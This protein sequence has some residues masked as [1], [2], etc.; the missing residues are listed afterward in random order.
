MIASDKIR[1]ARKEAQ[2]ARLAKKGDDDYSEFYA[3]QPV[4]VVLAER[5]AAI[6]A[7]K[8]ELK[9][10][11]DAVELAMV[12]G[13]GLDQARAAYANAQQ[14]LSIAMAQKMAIKRSGQA[15]LGAA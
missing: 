11:K 9:A 12:T 13:D 7:A 2:K 1:A 8:S 10:S 14:S 3:K 15:T 6:K 5:N 4:Q